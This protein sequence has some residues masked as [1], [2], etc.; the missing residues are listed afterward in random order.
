M[1]DRQE[2][3]SLPA[4]TLLVSLLAD[5]LLEL[6]LADILSMH[7]ETGLE[8]QSVGRSEPEVGQSVRTEEV[9]MNMQD[10]PVV[11]IVAGPGVANVM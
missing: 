2:D 8:I 4:D 9:D 3:Y 1:V 11:D 10:L 7:L 6:R 5:T